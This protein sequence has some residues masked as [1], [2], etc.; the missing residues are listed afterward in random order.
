MYVI[1]GIP[2]S[3]VKPPPWAPYPINSTSPQGI[4]TSLINKPALK[5]GAQRQMWKV[6]NVGILMQ[7]G[8]RNA[9]GESSPPATLRQVDKVKPITLGDLWNFASDDLSKSGEV[10]PLYL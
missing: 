10:R 9:I 5:R 1:A 2:H 4:Q 3:P 7:G 8:K 6:P